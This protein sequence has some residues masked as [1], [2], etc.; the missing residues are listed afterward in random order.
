MFGFGSVP[1]SYMDSEDLDYSAQIKCSFMFSFNV[2]FLV[3]F[4]V[5]F[6]VAA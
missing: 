4:I 1:R 3:Y 6:S 2:S 5:L